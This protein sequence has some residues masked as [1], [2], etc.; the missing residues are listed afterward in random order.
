[1]VAHRRAAD[2]PEATAT[3]IADRIRRWLVGTLEL[4][5]TV[6]RGLPSILVCPFK[7]LTS[8]RNGQYQRLGGF[9][10]GERCARPQPTGHYGSARG[11]LAGLAADACSD[12]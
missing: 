3:E 8:E 4:S 5:A 11:C 9:S 7:L 12:R 6:R 2:I 10:V 1:M